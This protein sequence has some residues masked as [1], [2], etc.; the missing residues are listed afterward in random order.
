MKSESPSKIYNSTLRGCEETPAYKCFYTFN[1]KDYRSEFKDSFGQLQFLNDESLSPRQNITYSHEENMRIVLLPIAGAIHYCKD[2]HTEEFV[3]SEQIK[4]L[5]IEKGLPYTF[6][7]PF[8]EEWINYL[9]IGFK[10]SSSQVEHP[11]LTQPIGFKKMNELVAFG[12][13]QQ[14]DQPT[15]CIGIYEGRSEGNYRLKKQGNGLFVYIISGAFEVQGRLME[16]RDGLSLWDTQEIEFEALSN[17]AIIL[18]LE[19]KLT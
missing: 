15:G 7:N 14:N 3:E 10:T 6:H 19:I 1:F 5:E 17:N 11:S 16:Y 12:W 2:R 8:E 4:I 18:L 9:H 13:D